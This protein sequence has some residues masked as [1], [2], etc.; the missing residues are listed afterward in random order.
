MTPEEEL[1]QAQAE[2]AR[3]ESEVHDEPAFVEAQ[4]NPI[5][6]TIAPTEVEAGRLFTGE[7]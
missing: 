4:V 5:T 3:L 6:G 1:A 2:V 7:D